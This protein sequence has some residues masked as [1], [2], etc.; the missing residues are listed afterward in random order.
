[1]VCVK[2]V[3]M[4][5]QIFMTLFFIE[6]QVSERNSLSPF[7]TE[8]V[9]SFICSHTC[10]SQTYIAPQISIAFAL[11]SSQFLYNKTPIAINAAIAATTIVTGHAIAAMLIPNIPAADEIAV[12]RC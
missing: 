4:E 2:N 5:F 11:I 10:E 1:M 8:A 3:P 7:H 9:V 12:K 6:S